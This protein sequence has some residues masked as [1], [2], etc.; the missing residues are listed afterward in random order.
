MGGT[1]Q[2]AVSND[3]NPSAHL[4]IMHAGHTGPG[5]IQQRH[6]RRAPL[7]APSRDDRRRCGRAS[8]GVGRASAI[9]PNPSLAWR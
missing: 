3:A 2:K 4:V 5:Y 9:C 8:G 6:A 7:D 1:A